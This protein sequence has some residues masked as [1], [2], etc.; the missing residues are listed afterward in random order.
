MNEEYYL[1]LDT[2]TEVC[3]VALATPDK[4]VDYAEA[5]GSNKHSEQL[6]AMAEK[7]LSGIDLKQLKAVGVSNGPGSYTGL[8]IGASYAKG[9]CWTLG[10][11]LVSVMTTE[12]LGMTLMEIED[13]QEYEDSIL[14]PMIDARRMEVYTALYRGRYDAHYYGVM[15][16]LTEI[17]AVVLTE[18][19][20]QEKV[21]ELVGDHHLI[22]FGNGAEKAEELFIHLL[23]DAQLIRDLGPRAD[24]M[25]GAVLTKLAAGDTEDVAYWEPYYLKEYEAK[26][27]VNK[28]LARLAGKAEGEK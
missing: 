10:I 12:L 18:E 20:S 8:R 21:K 19:K 4:V 14:M 5:K 28:V 25:L 7:V 24:A 26:K 13:E 16:P 3:S 27:S 15:E 22:Y 1:L 9:I 23:P 6:A 2:S 11:P 17:A